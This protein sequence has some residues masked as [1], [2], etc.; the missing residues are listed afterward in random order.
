MVAS[1]R[2]R[3]NTALYLVCGEEGVAGTPSHRLLL[4]DGERRTLAAPKRK[5]PRHL[6]PT[7][8]ILPDEALKTDLAIKMALK[9]FAKGPGPNGQGG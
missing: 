8:T 4:C 7:G 6:N 5:N 1:R 9:P 3:D 2:G